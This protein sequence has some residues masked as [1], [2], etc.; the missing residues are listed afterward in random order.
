MKKSRVNEIE[1]ESK[2]T[3]VVRRLD[4]RVPS[5]R[6]NYSILEM[7]DDLNDSKLERASNLAELESLL[8]K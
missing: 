8:N 3:L 6:I 1:T 4:W 7:V 5:S 2:K